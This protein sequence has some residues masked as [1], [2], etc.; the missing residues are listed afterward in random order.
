M[1]ADKFSP[2]TGARG[3]RPGDWAVIGGAD[4]VSRAIVVAETIADGHRTLWDHAVMCSRISPDGTVWIVE[5]MPDGAREVPWHYD[6]VPNRWSTGYDVPYSRDAGAASRRYIGVGYSF[7]DYQAL[8]LHA[9]HIPAPGLQRYI[10]STHHLICSQ[11]VDQA[12]QDAGAHL[13]DDGRWPGY[14]KPS[15]L[16]RLIGA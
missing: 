8:E 14:V 13:F 11:L 16:G 2:V 3:V 7:L 15:D 6:H 12:C 5:A 10:A 1:T 9:L 4:I